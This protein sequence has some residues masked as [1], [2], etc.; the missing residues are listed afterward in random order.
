M[1]QKRP[2]P[3]KP[4]GEPVRPFAET[5]SASELVWPPVTLDQIK[6]IDEMVRPE[7]E[8]GNWVTVES[9]EKS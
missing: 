3:G 7:F 4:L 1:K 2:I 5:F 6:K 9:E 8:T